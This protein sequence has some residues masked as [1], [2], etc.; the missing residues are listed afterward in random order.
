MQNDAP[1]QRRAVRHEAGSDEPCGASGRSFE[2]NESR[3]HFGFGS[4]RSRDSSPDDSD[5]ERLSSD[6][7]VANGVKSKSGNDAHKRTRTQLS[8]TQ[9]RMMKAIF[10]DYRTPTMHECELLGNEIGLARRV[11]QV[12]CQ[13]AR[14]KE[15]KAKVFG[16]FGITKKDDDDEKRDAALASTCTRCTL[17][18]VGFAGASQ[19]SGKT[20]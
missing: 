12:W 17:C 4:A 5:S 15:R 10:K 16:A 6:L 19:T 2:Q 1:Q 14:A 9:I 20:L 11:V 3:M 8:V 18:D 13:N 7:H